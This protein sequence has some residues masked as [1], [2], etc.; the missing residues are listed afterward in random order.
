VHV[1]VVFAHHSFEY[2]DIFGITDLD[3]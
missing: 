2:A 3:D 1:N